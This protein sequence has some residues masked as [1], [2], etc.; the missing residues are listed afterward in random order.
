MLFVTTEPCSEQMKD[1]GVVKHG[2]ILVTPTKDGKAEMI[3]LPHSVQDEPEW[4]SVTLHLVNIHSITLTPVTK[5][6]KEGESKTQSVS[7]SD[8]KVTINFGNVVKAKELKMQVTP[9]SS[10]SHHVVVTE[11][12]ACVT[13]KGNIC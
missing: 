4:D 7:P 8:K 6:G 3:S 1:G 10:S 9:A 2:D 5:D 11:V 12:K 13:K